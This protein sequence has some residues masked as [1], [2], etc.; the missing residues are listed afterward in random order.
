[1]SNSNA[2]SVS[3]FKGLGEAPIGN[4]SRFLPTLGGTGRMGVRDFQ[5]G[6]ACVFTQGL[7]HYSGVIKH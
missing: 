3:I 4:K 2:K 1:M 6:N 5:L 7:K